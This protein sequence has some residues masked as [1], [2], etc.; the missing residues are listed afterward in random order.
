LPR[1]DAP[2]STPGHR[3]G[4]NADPIRQFVLK[5]HSRCNLSC[6][7]CYVYEMADQSWRDRPR[8]IPP[9]VV[10]LA[11][12]RIAEHAATHRLARVGVVLHGGEPLLIGPD[13]IGELAST[14]RA[15]AAPAEVAPVEVALTVQTNGLP[16]D[17]AMLDTLAE[18]DIGVA[19]SLDGDRDAHDRHRRYANGRGSH[20]GV[21]AAL[22]LLG[23]AA[24]RRLFRGL[25]C[26][27]DL[28]NDPARCYRALLRFGPPR[29]DFLLPLGNWSAPP[30][31]RAPDPAAAPYG[32]W[33]GA[34][35]DEWYSTPSG[36]PEVRMFGEIIRLL[37]GG[38]TTLESLGIARPSVA[39]IETDGTLEFNDA[40]KSVFPGAPAS[41]LRLADNRIDDLLPLLPPTDPA[42]E[43]DK[44]SVR[45]VCGG[46]YYPHRYRAGSGF[47]NP[48]VYCPDLFSL[49]RHIR[50]RLECD[51]GRHRRA[52]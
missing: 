12:E 7:Y 37:L 44:C 26:T 35:F 24:Y 16:L 33:L 18:H 21:A 43:C 13:R 38:R 3:T 27:V 11:A 48:S 2:R 29:V 51:L 52:R 50:T 46:G 45:A 28:A 9:E 1:A 15:G 19:V 36:R 14:L 34:V 49:I 4:L 8:T 41:G 40:L 5:V 39:V 47:G 10:R 32:E 17:S 42:A 20:A 30:P 25:L 23:T 6:D 22:E 31:G